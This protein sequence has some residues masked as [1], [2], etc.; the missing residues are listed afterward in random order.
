MPVS[1]QQWL[2]QCNVAACR[3]GCCALQGNC[4]AVNGMLQACQL[5]ATQLLPQRT[6]YACKQLP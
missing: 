6:W 5:T 3:T 1:T 4:L 2:Y